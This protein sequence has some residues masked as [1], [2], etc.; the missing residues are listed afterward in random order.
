MA[1]QSVPAP[2][3]AQAAPGAPAPKVLPWLL[4]YTLGRLA[5][6]AVLVA[7]IWFAGL[8]GLPGLLFGVLLAMPVAYFALRPV[9]ERLTAAIVARAEAKEALRAR[10][11]GS[12]TDDAAS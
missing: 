3:G 1:D 7:V 9:R 11:R 4:A 8:P 6:V 10:L 12:D 2:T 5:I